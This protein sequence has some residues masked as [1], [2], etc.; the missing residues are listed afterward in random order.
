MNEC[1]ILTGIVNKQPGSVRFNHVC[2]TS[3]KQL[4]IKIAQT[5]ELYEDGQELIPKHVGEIIYQ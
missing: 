5:Y 4:D 3:V 1:A 2:K